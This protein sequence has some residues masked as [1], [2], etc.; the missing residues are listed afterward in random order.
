MSGA[1]IFQFR[2]MAPLPPSLLAALGAATGLGAVL[3]YA[4]DRWL[5]GKFP[6]FI[7]TLIFPTAMAALDFG[8]RWS[9][10]GSWGVLAYS[11]F[12]L[13]P[14]IQL[15]SVTGLYGVTFLVAW[16]GAVVNWAWMRRSHFKNTRAG[17]GI[18]LCIVAGVYLLGAI[19]LRSNIPG[20]RVRVAG[21]AADFVWDFPNPSAAQRFWSGQP[22]ARRDEA[23][24]RE[25]MLR[26]ADQLL[27]RTEHEAQ[28]GAKLVVWSEGAVWLWRTDEPMLLQKAAELARRDGIYIAL[29]YASVNP[30]HT[31]FHQNKTVFVGNTGGVLFEYLKSRPVP[32]GE[33]A[34]T[35][36]RPNPMFFADT[37]MGRIGAFICFDLDFPA[38]VQQAGRDRTDIVLA[39]SHDWKEIDPMH[40]RMAVFRAVENGF[41]FVRDVAEG[42]S[43]AVDYLGRTLAE[44][45]DF[46]NSDHVLRAEIPTRGSVTLYSRI[47]DAFGWLMV[48]LLGLFVGLGALR[49]KS[50]SELT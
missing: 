15:V 46:T 19:R 37:P 11:Q 33:K 40:T 27:A 1:W 32:G 43:I 28:A 14:L 49:R 34:T 16:F 31:R 23:K 42:R 26:R 39:P 48:A 45:D 38:L 8:T 10:Y 29:A 2:G 22:L 18:F 44:T 36:T 47:G 5:H 17:L 6:G 4:L 24:V 7:S 3:P 20:P 25:S 30:E 35:E 13:L 12:N 50:R 21:L 41:N 9:P